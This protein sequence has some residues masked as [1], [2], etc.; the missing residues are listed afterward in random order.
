MPIVNEFSRFAHEYGTYNQI[1]TQVATHLISLLDKKNYT[2]MVDIGAGSGAVYNALKL[3][4]IAFENFYALDFSTQMLQ[5]HP[6]DRVIKVHCDF[7]NKAFTKE[8]KDQKMS[9][10]LSS[11]ALQWSRDLEFTFAQIAELSD[12]FYFAIFTSNTFKTLHHEAKITS[13][14][15]DATT[16]LLELKKHFKIEYEEIREYKLH[17]ENTKEI[18][19]Y[20]KKSGV[21]GGEKRLDFR[22]TKYILQNYSLDYLEFEVLFVKGKKF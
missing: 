2:N 10:T 8:I 3:K 6:N 1:Q 13:P 16:L 21:S 4:N 9:V 20:I 18:F 17:F 7:N 12:D 14:I 11:S 22:S 5:L 19:N 15:Y